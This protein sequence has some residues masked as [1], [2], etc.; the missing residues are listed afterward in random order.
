[1]TVGVVVTNTQFSRSH[2]LDKPATGSIYKISWSADGTQV[3]FS[4]W[5][6]YSQRFSKVA[7][8][9]GNGQ[10]VFAHVIEKRLEWR[11]YEVLL[12]KIDW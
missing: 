2:S 3:S 8:A 11:D 5:Q 12:E 10:V 1:M 9:C 6:E 7:G 4:S